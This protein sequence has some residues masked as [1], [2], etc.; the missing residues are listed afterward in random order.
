[1][2]ASLAQEERR[3]R[4]ELPVQIALGSAFR[5]TEGYGSTESAAAYARARELCYKLGATSE[6]LPVLNGMWSYHIIYGNLQAAQE[7]ATECLRI[8]ERESDPGLLVQACRTA[9]ATDFWLGKFQGCR[10][11]MERGAGLYDV[12]RDEAKV[13]WFAVDGLVGCLIYQAWAAWFLGYPEQARELA[14]RAVEHARALK[15]H[16][17][18]AFALIYAS[19]THLS[20]REMPLAQAD[21]EEVL[22]LSIEQAFPQLAPM[23]QVVA[24]AGIA[25][26]GDPDRGLERIDEGIAAWSRLGSKLFIT[27]SLGWRADALLLGSRNTEAA[28]T[29]VEALRIADETGERFYEAELH[30]LHGQALLG[31]DDVVAERDFANAMEIARA[32]MAKSLKLRCGTGPRPVVAVA[33]AHCRSAGAVGAGL[34]PL[35]RRLRHAGPD[36]SA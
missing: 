11:H 14:R 10:E 29:V 19:T 20:R 28:A 2:T 27:L 1:M 35:Y 33:G 34:R 26:Q 9:G 7:L 24:G 15:H 6:L 13:G 12:E 5:V 22:R 17:T 25:G 32:Q 16:H 8:A 36:R 30:R 18:L 23:G 4:S 31:R 21:G 3:D